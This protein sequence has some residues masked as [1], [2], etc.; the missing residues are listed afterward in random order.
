LEYGAAGVTRQPEG[1]ARTAEQTISTAQE[2]LDAG[3]PF[4]AHEVFE[5]AW[6]SARGEHPNNDVADLWKGLAQAAVA[7]THRLRGNP[8]GAQRLRERAGSLLAAYRADPPYG[9]DL[10]GICAWAALAEP[11]PMPPLR[12]ASPAGAGEG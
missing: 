5:D 4:H 9:L 2:L 3:R 8:A 6:K 1:E 10:D 7:E 11:G 12:P